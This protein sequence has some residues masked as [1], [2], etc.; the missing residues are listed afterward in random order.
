MASRCERSASSAARTAAASAAAEAAGAR[1]AGRAAGR[2]SSCGGGR[3]RRGVGCWVV[4]CERRE[5]ATLAT[6][7][8]RASEAVGVEAQGEGPSRQEGCG[9]G[10]A[11][12]RCGGVQLSQR[13]GCTAALHS[14]PGVGGARLSIALHSWQVDRP[15]RRAHLSQLDHL[16][17]VGPL[18]LRAPHAHT[19]TR[20]CVPTHPYTHTHTHTH[21]RVSSHAQHAPALGRGLGAGEECKGDFQDFCPVC[22]TD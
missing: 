8:Q 2:A 22:A 12:L 13:W 16:S 11:Q 18:A 19:H 3:G 9:R 21:T 4:S 20:V 14:C 7:G 6:G 17:P 1:E 10:G 5:G 15:P